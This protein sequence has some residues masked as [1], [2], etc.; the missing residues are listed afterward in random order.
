MARNDYLKPLVGIYK[1]TNK[2]NNKV[3]IGQAKD[4]MDRWNMHQTLGQKGTFT[5]GSGKHLYMS[6]RKYGIENFTFEVVNV[7]KFEELDE[8][9]KVVIWHYEDEL[10][11]D[12][13]Y[14]TIFFE[15]E[16]KLREKEVV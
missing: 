12:N 6:M 10:G 14:N 4:I 8:I 3:Y 1:I 7:C 9:E 15:A 11:R 16:R 5:N 2:L 13:M